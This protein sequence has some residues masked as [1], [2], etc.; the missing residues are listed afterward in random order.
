M[1][2]AP[3]NESAIEFV[4]PSLSQRFRLISK[5]YG[6]L[7]GETEIARYAVLKGEAAD[8]QVDTKVRFDISFSKSG[9]GAGRPLVFTLGDIAVRVGELIQ[10]LI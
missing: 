10:K 3:S 2:R 1:P 6:P 8:V 5:S 4:P 7:E 9:P